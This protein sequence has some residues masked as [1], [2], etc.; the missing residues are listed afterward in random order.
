MILVV[1]SHVELSCM[2]ITTPT[3]LN[4]VLMSFRMPL[5]FFI[6]GYIAYKESLAWDWGIWRTMSRKKLVVQLVPT[7]ILGLLYTYAYYGTDWQTFV[8]ANGKL[9]YW[10]TIEIGRAHV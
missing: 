8:T 10:F 4:E 5:F 1:F 3:Y 6:S 9:G 2:G 7:L